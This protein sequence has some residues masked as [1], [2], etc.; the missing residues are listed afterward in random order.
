MNI[1]KIMWGFAPHYQFDL[2]MEDFKNV[3]NK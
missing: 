2:F 1:L 3:R